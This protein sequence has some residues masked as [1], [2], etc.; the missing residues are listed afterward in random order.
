MN[1][2]AQ[3]LRELAKGRDVPATSQTSYHRPGTGSGICKSVSV[4]SGKGGVGKTNI[5][6]YVSVFLSAF[7]K[8]V[9]LL[10][11]DLGLANV[12]IL[13][14]IAPDK[15]IAHFIDGECG[16]ERIICRG[17]GGIDIVPGASG[18]EKLA[19]IDLGRLE[20]LQHEFMKLE[21]QYDYLII[22]T[23]AGI[24]ST[25]THFASQTDITL[26]VMTTEPTS[27][28]DAY[29]MVKVLYDRGCGRVGVV[30]NMCLSEREGN[31]TFDRLNTLVVKFLKKPLELFG[32]M[33]MNPD[34]PQYVKKQK[35]I[36]L[37]KGHEQFNGKVLDIARKISGVQ[38][39]KKQSFFTRFWNKTPSVLVE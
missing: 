12:H 3:K 28:A 33:L 31:E 23:G 6:L 22:D 5:A 8:K 18:L 15:N 9:L 17:P 10:D 7:R 19:N 29:A 39:D 27:L 20:L 2:Q 1:D 21:S 36:V 13:L 11:A 30:V 24:G 4:T 38:I 26:L 32:C 16:I 14:G 37:D 34:V 25:V 35:L